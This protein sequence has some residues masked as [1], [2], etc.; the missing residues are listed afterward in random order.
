M[1]APQKQNLD[2]LLQAMWT[3]YCALNPQA[4]K[5]YNL[6]ESRGEKL[7][8]DH[9]ALRTFQHPKL[10]IKHLAR[11][12]VELGY[13][14]R[15]EYNFEQKK[16]YAQHFEHRTEAHRPK[17]FIS[18]L[19]VDQ[20]SPLVQ[21]TVDYI[22]E[23]LSD[24]DLNRPDVSYMGR[25]W[26]LKHETYLK[27][28]KESEYAAWLASL[29]FRPNHFTINV[30]AL[31]TFEGLEDL[32]AFLETEGFQLNS[33]GGKI[34]G[35][36]EQ[37]LE[38]SSTLAESISVHFEEGDFEVPSCYY[39]FAKRYPLPDGNLYQG[40]VAQSADKIFESTDRQT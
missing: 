16:L 39:E 36:S 28:L 12:F 23:Q 1:S 24:E 40:F 17:I 10:G 29:G 11:Q 27:L 33:S 7:E 14:A 37:F 3:D 5:I 30:N 18:E 19:K 2:Q 6:L 31:K 4:K 35:S 8:N 9:I 25:P 34:K 22:L 13:E 20:F 38:Q 26:K 32:N 21:Q 15:G